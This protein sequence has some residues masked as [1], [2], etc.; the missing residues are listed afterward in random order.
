MPSS[1]IIGQATPSQHRGSLKAI[2]VQFISLQTC[3]EPNWSVELYDPNDLRRWKLTVEGPAG[4]PYENGRFKLTM[5][6]PHDFPF[7]E[8]KIFFNTKIFHPN[9]SSMG[10]ICLEVLANGWSPA[11]SIRT[12][13]RHIQELLA[14][15]NFND[16]IFPEAAFLFKEN[17]VKFYKTATEWTRN[18]AS[19]HDLSS[20]G[21]A[22]SYLTS[23]DSPSKSGKVRKL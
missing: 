5:E 7:R 12:I 9:I 11:L 15:P 21:K 3:V 2:H 23:A 6:F 14:N 1:F 4:T 8:P 10:L 18:Y 20:S 19:E 22:T 17:R 16:F 13:M